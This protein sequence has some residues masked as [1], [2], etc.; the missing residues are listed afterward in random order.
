MKRILIIATAALMLASC[1]G[2]SG[3][4]TQGT[5][6][7]QS[8]Q[9]GQTGQTTAKAEKSTRHAKAP[10]LTPAEIE[11]YGEIGYSDIVSFI[12]VGYQIHWEEG[13]PEVLDLSS[14]YSYCSPYAG[15]AMKDINGDGIKE[16]MIGDQF[17]DGSYALYD[18]YTI[19]PKDASLIHLAKGGERDR[20]VINGSGIIVETGSNSADDSFTRG[21]TISGGELVPVDAWDDDLMALELEKFVPLAIASSPEPNSGPAAESL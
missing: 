21:F 6:S 4:G 2:Q 7:S 15:F 17:E 19:N 9:T 11:E 3:Q 13:G 10:A 14:V 20:F 1:G 5:Q 16:L 12:V 8:S 18:I